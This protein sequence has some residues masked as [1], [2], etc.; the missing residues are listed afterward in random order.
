LDMAA[1]TL[2]LSVN[3]APQPV[4]TGISAPVYPL[5]VFYSSPISAKLL[6][7]KRVGGGG[8]GGGGGR[9]GG[10]DVRFAALALMKI[11]KGISEG[12]VCPGCTCIVG[13][14]TLSPFRTSSA[15]VV[16]ARGRWLWSLAG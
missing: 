15:H 7:I 16:S 13:P 3:D 1:G 6:S 4:W 8:G 9:F 5:T 2:A 10:C 12:C 11:Y 14:T